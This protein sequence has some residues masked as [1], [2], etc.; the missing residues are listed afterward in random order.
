M[1]MAAFSIPSIHD[2]QYIKWRYAYVGLRFQEFIPALV[3]NIADPVVYIHVKILLYRKPDLRGIKLTHILP[4]G[5]RKVPKSYL[6]S[7]P[8]FGT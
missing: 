5:D 3:R 2:L 4:F 1:I 7:L 6:I 8:N